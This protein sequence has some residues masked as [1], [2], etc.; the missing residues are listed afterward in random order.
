MLRML[1]NPLLAL[2]STHPPPPFTNPA[3]AH[4]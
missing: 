4:N 3:T 1:I 2:S